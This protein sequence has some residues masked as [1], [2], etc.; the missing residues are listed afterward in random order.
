MEQ[1][2]KTWQAEDA[3]L[4]TTMQFFADELLPYFHIEGK[5]IGFGP[6]ELVRL[7][8]Q[9]LFQDF[10]LIMEDG[11]WKHFEF[12]SSDSK[13]ADLKRFRTYEA[14]T[15]YQQNVDVYTYVLYSGNIKEPVTEL[16][17]GFNTYRVHPI[18]MKGKRAEEVFDNIY[19]KVIAN[20]PLTKED[21]VPLTLCV[22][23][24]GD[25]P[26]ENR[27]IEAFHIT[28]NIRDYI[29][30]VDK[31]EAVVYAMAEKFLD[32]ATIEQLKEAVGMTRLGQMMYNDGI[33]EG[34]ENTQ[35]RIAK[36]LLETLPDEVIAEKTGL[37]LDIVKSLHNDPATMPAE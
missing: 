2:K 36:N 32:S 22:L 24:G 34:T 26:L 16:N 9:K 30:D 13:T 19:S 4:K 7:E 11:S 10:N 5:V 25:M 8:L 6:T 14:A 18:I 35:L 3:A 28:K 20:I 1:T 17:T 37:S 15:S 21:I 33:A 27:V 29:P 12:Q 23:M 31:I